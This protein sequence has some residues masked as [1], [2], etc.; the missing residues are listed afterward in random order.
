[1]ATR[2]YRKSQPRR[3]RSVRGSAKRYTY[4]DGKMR[5]VRGHRQSTA[6]MILPLVDV[7][8]MADLPMFEKAMNTNNKKAC[9]VWAMWC[10]HCHTMMPHFDAAAKSPNRSIQAIKVE[11]KML[12][13]VNRILTTKV[14]RNAKPI[15]VE[16][17]PSII[18]VD[19][20]GNKMTDI[21]PVRDTK[22]MTKVMEQVGPLATEAGLNNPRLTANNAKN[23]G[24]VG[25]T[26]NIN[27][28]NAAN[29]AN[30]IALP[31]APS[32][33]MNKGNSGKNNNQNKGNA[34]AKNILANI[35]IANEGLAAG[36]KNIDVGEDE[37][38]GSIASNRDKNSNIKLNSMKKNNVAKKGN[39]IKIGVPEDAVAPSPINTTPPPS[40]MTAEKA[41]R[42]G[43]NNAFP[44]SMRQLSEEAEKITSMTAPLSPPSASGDLEQNPEM[45]EVEDYSISN[46]LTAEQ[47]VSGGG[48]GGSLYAAMAR[49]A[50]TLAPAAA[51]L[52]TAAMVMKDKRRGKTHKSTKKGMKRRGGSRRRR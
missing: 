40:S 27:S 51:L 3:R 8:T 31:K 23:M 22:V 13:E 45:S 12:P 25:P 50:Y 7:R 14:N 43:P 26:P 47:R 6:G 15:N 30:M 19:E 34:K 36:P 16:G 9:M 4:T 38:R 1:M 10:P 20:K 46:D 5:S 24:K 21:E 2:K 28:N 32:M 18:L 41:L 48:R 42:A 39:S 35:G 49:T 44:K 33:N 52:A 11:E 29:M 17:Y 37:L